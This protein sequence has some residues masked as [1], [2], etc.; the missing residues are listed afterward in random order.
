MVVNALLSLDEDEL[1]RLTN[2][3]NNAS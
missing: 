3:S 2:A 1:R